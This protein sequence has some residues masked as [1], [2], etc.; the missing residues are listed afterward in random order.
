MSVRSS[1]ASIRTT[2]MEKTRNRISKTLR[3]DQGEERHQQGKQ[4]T[5]LVGKIFCTLKGAPQPSIARDRQ[6]GNWNWKSSVRAK[7]TLGTGVKAAV[8]GL[9]TGEGSRITGEEI[10]SGN[11]YAIDK[12]V[13]I[14]APRRK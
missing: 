1:G 11:L 5:P 10:D 6:G 8:W 4:G 9:G 3:V 14:S 13:R 12:K 2:I 7:T